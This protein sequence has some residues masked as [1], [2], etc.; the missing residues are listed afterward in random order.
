VIT[1]RACPRCR[2]DLYRDQDQYGAFDSC[3]QCG[4][5]VDIAEARPA[6]APIRAAHDHV[7]VPVRAAISAV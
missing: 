1:F 3:I 4:A 6:A 2:G 7:A 5:I